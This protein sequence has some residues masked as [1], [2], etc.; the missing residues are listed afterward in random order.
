MLFEIYFSHN[1][2]LIII[3][4]SCKGCSGLVSVLLSSP[5][6]E[7]CCP[8]LQGLFPPPPPLLPLPPLP[9][10]PP[11]PP[12]EL[13][14]GENAGD[15]VSVVTCGNLPE[16]QR[17]VPAPLPEDH[18]DLRGGGRG[19]AGDHLPRPGTP[20]TQPPNNRNHTAI[21]KVKKHIIQYNGITKKKK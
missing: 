14:Q 13:C 9:P 17:G 19:A 1:A 11:P 3:F 2:I 10:P 7:S 18:P 5:M 15:H 8:S 20:D 21:H 16:L 6:R 4:T 12:P